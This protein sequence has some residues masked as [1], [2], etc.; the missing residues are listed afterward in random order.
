ME[1]KIFLVWGLW[2]GYANLQLL[3]GNNQD[4]LEYPKQK[5]NKGKWYVL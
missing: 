5:K 1:T 3:H 4:E 2:W